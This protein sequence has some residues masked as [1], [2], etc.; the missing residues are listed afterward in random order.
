MVLL[1]AVAGEIDMQANHLGGMSN[2]ILLLGPTWFGEL[3]ACP[4]DLDRLC[5]IASG[6]ESE[7]PGC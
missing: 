2:S 1:K 5:G 7:S 6:S 3:Q 4:E